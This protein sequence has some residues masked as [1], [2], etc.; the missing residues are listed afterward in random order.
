V[1]K[2]VCKFGNAVG[3]VCKSPF[4]SRFVPLESFGVGNCGKV[5]IRLENLLF[6]SFL[7]D[8]STF[9]F[10]T[11][12]FAF[13]F[14][15]LFSL[16]YPSERKNRKKFSTFVHRFSFGF[17]SVFP[18]WNVLKKRLESRLTD[19]STFSADSTTFTSVNSSILLFFYAQ[20]RKSLFSPHP[21]ST[22]V[23]LPLRG[24][25]RQ[26]HCFG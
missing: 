9:W 1:K 3:K 18:F 15:F 12:R 5:K 21:P 16:F 13:H 26:S 10:S 14:L 20:K 8:F 23:P 7:S 25:G 17:P 19:L 6:C 4:R 24:E 2:C 11:L 22:M